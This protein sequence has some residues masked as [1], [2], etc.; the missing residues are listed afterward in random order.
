[1]CAI[2]QTV[3]RKRNSDNLIKIHINYDSDATNFC[4]RQLTYQPTNLASMIRFRA[5]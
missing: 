3:K 4:C 5:F 1:M 2:E